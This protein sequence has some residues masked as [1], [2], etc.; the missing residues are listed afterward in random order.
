ML[1]RAEAIRKIG[2]FHPSFFAYAEDVEWSLRAMEAGIRCFFEP[3]ATLWHKMFGASVKEGRR[4]VSKGAPRV[5]FLLSRNWFSLLRLHTRPW[6]LR[7]G[8]ALIYHVFIRRLPRGMAL[9]MLKS[10]RAA[11]VEL[12]L[13]LWAGWRCRPDPADCWLLEGKTDHAYSAE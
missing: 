11:G 13:G 10:R 4:V 5:E 1:I 9:L 3:S 2:L 6:S 8:F 7:R 12:F